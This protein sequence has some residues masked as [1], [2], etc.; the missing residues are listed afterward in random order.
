MITIFIGLVSPVATFYIHFDKR[1]LP[2]EECSPKNSVTAE[3]TSCGLV[4]LPVVCN[5]FKFEKVLFSRLD[6]FS[7]NSR[8]AIYLDF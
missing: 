7:C 1:V 4:S 3:T 8:V 6:G 5:E 2:A